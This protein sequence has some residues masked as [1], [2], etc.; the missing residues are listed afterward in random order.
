MEAGSQPSFRKRSSINITSRSRFTNF[1]SDY[2][3]MSLG[4]LSAAEVRQQTMS[5][6]MKELSRTNQK[7]PAHFSLLASQLAGQNEKTDMSKDDCSNTSP[8]STSRDP[9][10]TSLYSHK[11][12][13]EFLGNKYFESDAEIEYDELV[14]LMHSAYVSPVFGSS[15]TPPV[16]KSSESL[17]V[18]ALNAFP[19]VVLAL[20]LNLLD[21]MSYGIIIFPASDI[22]LP[23]TAAQAG[24]SMFLARFYLSYPAR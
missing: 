22:H 23:S 16:Q 8:A 11:L 17:V 18:E 5:W 9:V 24:I 12:G 14:P 1:S 21:A 4:S 10:S 15:T 13:P 6:T 2:D 3:Q 7:S 19:A 20:L